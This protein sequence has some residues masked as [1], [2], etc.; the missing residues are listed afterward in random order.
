MNSWIASGAPR[1]TS[2]LR[3]P[4]CYPAVQQ[5]INSTAR[6]LPLI[7]EDGP[8]YPPVL[9]PYWKL[10]G[11]SRY[12]PWRKKC[13]LDVIARGE[14]KI[15]V[16]RRIDNCVH[17]GGSSV[18]S[19]GLPHSLPTVSLACPTFIAG[20]RCGTWFS[21]RTNP[22]RAAEAKAGLFDFKCVRANGERCAMT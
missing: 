22:G 1:V 6:E 14:R 17:L 15:V 11:S 10:L 21:V 9:L 5:E 7:Q 20:Y 16:G 4:G 3:T 8:P 12:G 13:Q 18:F 19:N 2:R